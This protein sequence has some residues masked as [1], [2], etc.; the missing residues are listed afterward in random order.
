MNLHKIASS[1]ISAVNPFVSV[2]FT[3]N[4]GYTTDT[5]GTRIPTTTTTTTTGQFQNIT[6][7]ELQHLQG[8]NLQ[9]DLGVLFVNGSFDGVV[10]K[11]GKGGDTVTFS[12]NTWLVVQVLEQWPDWCKLAICL[13][14]T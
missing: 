2:V 12:S 4:T 11:D 5:D 6:A 13:Q 14:D 1:A 8:M 3:I 7:K 9:G 10:R